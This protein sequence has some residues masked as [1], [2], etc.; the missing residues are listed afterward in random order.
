MQESLPVPILHHRVT[1]GEDNHVTFQNDWRVCDA[2]T[3]KRR[4]VE[5]TEVPT[6]L[7]GYYTSRARAELPRL[8]H[9]NVQMLR[10]N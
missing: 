5:E 2:N 7:F 6:T 10:F 3:Q 9:K 1:V 4:V 8:P